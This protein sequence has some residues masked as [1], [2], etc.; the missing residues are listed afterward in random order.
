MKKF[1]V[2]DLVKDLRS[3]LVKQ[4][5]N[6]YNLSQFDIKEINNISQE[7]YVDDLSKIDIQDLEYPFKMVYLMK[8]EN[9]GLNSDESF[10]LVENWDNEAE[11]K[12]VMSTAEALELGIEDISDDD[13]EEYLSTGGTEELDTSMGNAIFKWDNVAKAYILYIALEGGIQQ[14]KNITRNMIL[15]M[16]SA[17][18]IGSYYNDNLRKNDSY[19]GCGCKANP[20]EDADLAQI[21]SKFRSL[22]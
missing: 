7:Y 16:K 10:Y 11:W 5:L 6:K 4:Y 21:P 18:S 1:M 8:T 14:Y 15:A 20:C 2:A 17:D 22:F 3:D 19:E 9:Y 13:V 12:D